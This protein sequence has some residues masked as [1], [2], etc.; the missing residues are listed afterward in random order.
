MRV[1]LLCVLLSGCASDRYLSRDE[2]D[3]M[4]KSCEVHGCTVIPSP[5][6]EQIKRLLGVEAI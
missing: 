1:L 5:L 6:W 4:R 3:M 2:E